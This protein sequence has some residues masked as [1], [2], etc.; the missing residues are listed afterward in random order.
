MSARATAT[1]HVN[2]PRAA[3]M[4]GECI[5]RLHGLHLEAIIGIHPHEQTAMQPI[6]IDLLLVI[7]GTPAGR[8]DDIRDTVDYD[9]VVDAIESM[10]AARRFNLLEHLSQ[11]MLEMI[12]RRFP[13]RRVEITI[14]KPAAVPRARSVSVSRQ[15]EWNSNGS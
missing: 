3:M 12:G 14:A 9:Q 1:D 4:T 13:V 11:A 6:E 10:L 7:D 2:P 5:I 15:A 8:S